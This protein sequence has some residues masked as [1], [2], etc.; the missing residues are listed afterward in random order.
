MS[1]PQTYPQR[2]HRVSES[3]NMGQCSRGSKNEICGCCT[4]NLFSERLT[5]HHKGLPAL[6]PLEESTQPSSGPTPLAQGRY[7][8]DEDLS[9]SKTR[10]GHIVDLHSNLPKEG[11]Y[12]SLI[13]SKSSVREFRNYQRSKILPPDNIRAMK[14]KDLLLTHDKEGHY[15]VIK[16]KIRTPRGILEGKIVDSNGK[17]NF[18]INERAVTSA[19][20]YTRFG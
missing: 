13:H 19:E 12:G 3:C 7:V 18:Y 9:R 15:K 17:K 20:Y 2:S 5:G 14:L 1:F 10:R 4:D 11:P 16:Q 8:W 6:S